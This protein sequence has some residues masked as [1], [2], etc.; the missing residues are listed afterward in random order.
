[1]L[2]RLWTL[3]INP[4]GILLEPDVDSALNAY[5]GYFGYP[6]SSRM[7]V[8]DQ[9]AIYFYLTL[10]PIQMWHPA[11]FSPGCPIVERHQDQFWS[12]GAEHS[13]ETALE[14]VFNFWRSQNLW[15][16]A[17]EQIHFGG[18]M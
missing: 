4:L 16:Q 17:P 11:L 6:H 14:L 12:F 15:V 18:M 3:R 7:A 2:E 9:S 1:M 8:P 5:V 13:L 10:V